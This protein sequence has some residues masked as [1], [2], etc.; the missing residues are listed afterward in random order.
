MDYKQKYI[1]YKAKYLELRNNLNLPPTPSTPKKP[2]YKLKL[3]YNIK[4]IKLNFSLDNKSSTPS[5]SRPTTDINPVNRVLSENEKNYSSTT[6]DSFGVWSNLPNELYVIGDVHGDFFALKQ[7]LELTNCV[8]FDQ[9]D[10]KM[11]Y[12]DKNNYYYLNDGCDFYN[13][14]SNVKWNPN[15]INCF[16]VFAGDI[17][18]RCRPHPRNNPECINTVSDENCDYKMLKLLYELDEQAKLYNSRLLVVLG[19]HELLNISNDIRYASIKGKHDESRLNNIKDLLIKNISNIFGV[20]RINRYIIVHGGINDVFFNNFNKIINEEYSKS[21]KNTLNP[22]KYESIQNFNFKLQKYIYGFDVNLDDLINIS[23]FWDRTIGGI[24]P[25]NDNQ[26]KK[27]FDEN[28]LNIKNV[29]SNTHLK[30]IVAHCPQFSNFKS[31]NI[32]PC[33]EYENRIYRIDVGMSRA[34][35]LY[36]SIDELMPLLNDDNILKMNID[37]FFNYHSDTNL[38]RKVSVLKITNNKEESLKGKL[39]TEYFYETAFKNNELN[40]RF[41]LF[42]DIKKIYVYNFVKS[43]D[44]NDKQKYKNGVKLINNILKIMS[45]LI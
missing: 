11:K 27:I 42:S 25:L 41:H 35:D 3:P 43:L 26:C 34:F 10:E 38:T 7:S 28:V 31:I 30:I 8:H 19:N 40:K 12:D 20:V 9:Y 44:F 39:S 1:K 15:K 45:R 33:Q 37:N 13:V 23:P 16:I 14:N 17:V 18:D 5:I 24:E 6:V 4:P 36:K 2:N 21:P 22:E 32:Q 29:S